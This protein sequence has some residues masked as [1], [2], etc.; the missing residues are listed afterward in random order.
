MFKHA[1]TREVAYGSLPARR[2]ARAHAD[3][4][5]WLEHA[6]GGRQR[7]R[8]PVAHHYAEAV[9]PERAELAWPT[10][11]RAQT[12]CDGERCGG[13]AAPASSPSGDTSWPTRP[14]C[15]G[16]RSSSSPTRRCAVN[17]GRRGESEHALVRYR[18][19]RE[20]MERALE[21]RPP[22]AAAADLYAK[23]ARGLPPVHVEASSAARRR[24][25]VDRVRAGV[26]P[27]W[28]GGPSMAVAA[29]GHLD[30]EPAHRRTGGSRAR[31]AAGRANAAGR[32]DETQAKVATAHG[33][34][35][36]AATYADRSSPSSPEWPIPTSAPLSAWWPSSRI[37]AWQDPRRATRRRSTRRAH[38]SPDAS[39]QI[40]S[41]ASCA[42]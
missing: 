10:T 14:R 17:S 20:A 1:L 8:A 30:P 9:A 31:R 19:L 22:R 29:W 35:E 38:H 12:P 3:F 32:R 42:R 34:L 16:T 6:A 11:R 21:L 27:A 28:L 36:E 39:S 41:A 15:I 37:C 25:A 24:R 40:H 18:R 7:A 26:G 4:A 2:K 5:E 33:R 23:L 13:C